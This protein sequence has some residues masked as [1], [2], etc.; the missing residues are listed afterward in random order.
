MRLQVIGRNRIAFTLEQSAEV[1]IDVLD[2]MGRTVERLDRA[3]F[4][5]GTH[6]R[7]WPSGGRVRSGVYFVRIRTDA[8]DETVRLAVA[9]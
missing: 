4:A 8:I 1:T 7:E 3:T 6:E 5:A 9:R 2:A